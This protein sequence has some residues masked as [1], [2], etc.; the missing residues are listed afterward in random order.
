MITFWYIMAMVYCVLAMIGLVK[1]KTEED[2][3]RAWI[4]LMTG[5]LLLTIIYFGNRLL[6]R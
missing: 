1:S 5:I 6:Q 3:T 2:W 4:M